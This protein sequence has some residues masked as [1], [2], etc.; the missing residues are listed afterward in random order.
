MSAERG[1][2]Y[3]MTSA[4]MPDLYKIGASTN[5]PLERA[6]QLTMSTSA[7]SPFFVAYHR[8]VIFP[9]QVEAVI[10]RI[11]KEHR[12]NDSREFFMVPLARVIELF[13]KV[14]ACPECRDLLEEEPLPWS[15]LFS[16]FPDDGRPRELNDH[17]QE[18]CADLAH[19][20]RTGEIIH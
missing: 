5:H 14:E 10:H 11:L 2:I 8:H 17:E 1:Y 12:V 6:K 13:D 3:C 9:F 4:S 19:K 7:A 20:I 16:S 15:E 18:L